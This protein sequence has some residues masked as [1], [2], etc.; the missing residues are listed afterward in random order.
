LVMERE[1]AEALDRVAA[2]IADL[3]GA[4]KDPIKREAKAPRVSSSI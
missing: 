3:A 1:Q 4:S 2:S